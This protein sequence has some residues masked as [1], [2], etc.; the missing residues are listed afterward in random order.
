MLVGG[1]M[2]PVPWSPSIF[3][4]TLSNQYASDEAERGKLAQ[5]QIK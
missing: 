1:K 4:L 3:L 5:V 2:G